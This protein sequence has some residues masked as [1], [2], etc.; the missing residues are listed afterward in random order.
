MMKRIHRLPDFIANQIAAGEVVER[1]VSV[2]KELLENAI[3]AGAS[4]IEVFV[5]YGGL[6]RIAVRDNGQGIHP[7][8][9]ELAVSAHATS[10]IHT[11]KDLEAIQTLGFRGEALASIASVSK[12]SIR[13]KTQ[14][15]SEALCLR[16]ENA[17]LQ[18]TPCA[19]NIGTTVEAAELF[20]NAP[21]R[22]KFLKSSKTEFHAIELLVKRY[23]MARL[24]VAFSL[25]H[26]GKKLWDLPQ[27]LQAGNIQKRL[28]K[29]MGA[30]FAAAAVALDIEHAGLRLHGWYTRPEYQRNQSDGVCVFVNGRLVKDK[31]LL[32]S[33]KK[34]Y[35][36][37]LLPGKYP[38]ALLYLE[39]DSAKVDVNVHPTKHEV[40]FLEPR[41][42]HDFI[43]QSLTQ[44]LSPQAGLEKPKPALDSGHNLTTA[45]QRFSESYLP[46]RR[47]FIAKQYTL[48]RDEEGLYL[49]DA[50]QARRFALQHAIRHWG[51]PW[52][53]RPLL[54]P[55]RVNLSDVTDWSRL[56]DW[57]WRRFGFELT[58]EPPQIRILAIPAGLPQLP[59]ETF[60]CKLTKLSDISDARFIA[61]AI[62]AELSV[63]ILESELEPML[64]A[65]LAH[66][67][68]ALQNGQSCPGVVSITEHFCQKVLYET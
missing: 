29:T 21:V 55:Y 66:A 7:D 10:K 30:S 4:R 57:D 62:D 43:F 52:K 6:N 67:K 20:F 60:F 32:H 14:D 38:S 39:L 54:L 5:E 24:D 8:D 11:T 19:H 25:Y 34:A 22:K 50:R 37:H 23:A 16:V 59:L 26:N 42:V 65:Y 58:L 36:S 46:Q 28:Q 18:T 64:K 40:R 31:L 1:P 12:F 51:F 17:V 9:L 61:E 27:A 3:D 56:A 44:A 53:M 33:I 47:V 48:E 68:I 13:S 49:L 63:G 2:V 15:M 35:A 41:L 45:G